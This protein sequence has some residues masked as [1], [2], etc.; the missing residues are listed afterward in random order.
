[1][2]INPFAGGGPVSVDA[3]EPSILLEVIMRGR[4]LLA[5]EE[6]MP[7]LAGTEMRDNLL[8]MQQLKKLQQGHLSQQEQQQKERRMAEGAILL[9]HYVHH[10]SYQPPPPTYKDH[11]EG[12]LEKEGSSMGNV[13]GDAR[14][15][16]KAAIGELLR[17]V[18]VGGLDDQFEAIFRRVF[19]SRL[20][21]RHLVNEM[22]IRHVRGLLLYGEDNAFYSHTES[23]IIA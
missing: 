4:R 13:E 16:T 18:G 12:S 22:G 21:P 1:L 15:S 23:L 20:L 9:G 7:S 17:G 3:A 8:A 5:E 19:A 11:D 14:G 2:V 10:P 6:E